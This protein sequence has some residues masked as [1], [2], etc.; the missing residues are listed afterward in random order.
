MST[1][2]TT[3]DVTPVALFTTPRVAKGRLTSVKIDNQGTAARTIRIQ[4]RFT[5]D[6]SAGVPA[7]TERVIDRVQLTVGAGLTETL[8]SEQLEDIQ[9]LGTCEAVASATDPA[10]VIII[11]Y[12]FV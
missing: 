1:V 9:I 6:P 7:P 12:H 11:G 5:P 10:T 8:S 3:A 4:D 2:R